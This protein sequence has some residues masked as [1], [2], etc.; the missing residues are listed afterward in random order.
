MINSLLGT[1]SSEI[2]FAMCCIAANAFFVTA[3]FA[4]VKVRSSRIQELVN[5]GNRRASIVSKMLDDVEGFLSATQ[6]GITVSSLGLGWIGEPAIASL[7]HSR[8]P[9]IAAMGTI[10]THTVAVASSFALITFLQ[11]VLGELVPRA[12]AIRNAEV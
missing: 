8:L 2:F 12:I 9:E 3:E 4:L 7:I 11:I 1:F 6:F 10:L 5:T